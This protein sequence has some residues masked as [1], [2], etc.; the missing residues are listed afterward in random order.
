LAAALDDVLHQ[1]GTGV[2][3]NS[4]LAVIVDRAVPAIDGPDRS[5][6]LATGDEPVLD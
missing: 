2:E 1:A 5:D 3:S 6:V 4:H